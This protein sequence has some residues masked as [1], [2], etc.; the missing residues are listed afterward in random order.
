MRITGEQL[1][2]LAGRRYMS[3]CEPNASE[4]RIGSVRRVYEYNALAK[5]YNLSTI[6]LVAAVAAT[7]LFS[8]AT[9]FVWGAIGLLVRYVAGKEIRTYHVPPL[10]QA[11][12]PQQAQPLLAMVGLNPEMFQE[13]VK[14]MHTFAY[15][16]NIRQRGGSAIF[17]RLNMDPVARWEEDKWIIDDFPLWKN[18]LP[19][20]ADPNRASSNS[21]AN[22]QLAVGQGLAAGI[23]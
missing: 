3:Y 21:P 6:L 1:T 15:A 18:T 4:A 16:A 2:A 9:A 7:I 12:V 19:V 10:N 13:I 22:G 14:A 23:V 5:I 17:Q 8:Y 11:Q 20:P